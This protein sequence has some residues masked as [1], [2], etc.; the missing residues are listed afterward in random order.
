MSVT[1]NFCTFPNV[2]ATGCSERPHWANGSYSATILALG[3]RICPKL[4]IPKALELGPL[5]MCKAVKRNVCGY[6]TSAHI[7]KPHRMTNPGLFRVKILLFTP[8]SPPWMQHL[9]I[10]NPPV[11]GAASKGLCWIISKRV[12]PG[13]PSFPSSQICCCHAGVS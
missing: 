11:P 9:L 8:T 4:P 2:L 6:K 10:L 3:T 12:F 7:P 13:L 1:S 5:S